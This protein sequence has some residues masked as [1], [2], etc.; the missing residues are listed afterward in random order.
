M[1]TS[2]LAFLLSLS[3]ERYA[4]LSFSQARCKSGIESP[5]KARLAIN[6]TAKGTRSSERR[7]RSSS[8]EDTWSP[9]TSTKVAR[10]ASR[11]KGVNNGRIGFVHLMP[12]GNSDA[13]VVSRRVKQVIESSR[14]RIRRICSW[15]SPY[16]GVSKLSSSSN[17]GEEEDWRN[18]R[19]C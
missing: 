5:D 9:T 6:V 17:I 10:A 4:T 7:R 12:K 2:M 16:H 15:F 1:D 14:R 13:L 18:R 8:G 3:P 11:V 19:N